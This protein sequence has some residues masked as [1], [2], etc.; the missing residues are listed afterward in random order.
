MSKD[1]EKVWVFPAC[2]LKEFDGFPG[3]MTAPE[4]WTTFA[5]KVLETCRFMRRGDV[6]EA[7]TVQQVIP[8][9]L[10]RWGDR[11]LVYNRGA[12]GGE[13]R[14]ADK[15]SIGVGGH[16]NPQDYDKEK[17]SPFDVLLN[18]A[19]RELGEELTAAGYL[20][21]QPNL[22]F[23]GLLK[24]DV[25]SVDEVHFGVVFEAPFASIAEVG[26]SEEIERY[27]WVTVD[28]LRNYSLELWSQLVL[29]EI[30]LKEK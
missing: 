27:R 4:A 28:E 24:T 1:D 29:E 26:G 23:R 15:W 3:V 2:M 11:V 12:K 6:E 7:P 10:V 30:L 18:C 5:H 17:D 9:V 16:V 8:Y 13:K 14:L 25:T 20:T 19:S 21:A 22:V